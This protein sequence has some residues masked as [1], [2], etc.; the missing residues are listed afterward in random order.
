M[1]TYL[2]NF[3]VT[4]AS[5]VIAN[6]V[7][8][9]LR[10]LGSTEST[11]VQ[12]INSRMAGFGF[13]I[14]DGYPVFRHSSGLHFYGIGNKDG[15]NACAPVFL[16]ADLCALLERPAISG[17]SQAAQN[18]VSPSGVS[19]GDGLL[20]WKTY[21][22]NNH[23]GTPAGHHIYLSQ[24]SSGKIRVEAVHRNGGVLFDETYAI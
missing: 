17:L 9:W 8:Q 2:D 4:T 15:L 5:E 3:A 10:T 18:W 21:V 16:G 20:T 23:Y 1:A 24:P 13:E 22:E 19:V 12:E 14:H 6:D 11:A 7:N